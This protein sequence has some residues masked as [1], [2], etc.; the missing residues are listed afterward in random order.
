LKTSILVACMLLC[1]QGIAMLLR[2]WST[3]AAATPDVTQSG[4]G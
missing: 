2:L 1:L 3:D 4:D